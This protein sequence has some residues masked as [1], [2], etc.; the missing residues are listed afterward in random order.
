LISFKERE[1]IFQ[2]KGTVKGQ[3]FGFALAFVGDWNHDHR[4]D[5]A[6][7]GGADQRVTI[8]SGM[9]HSTIRTL[10]AADRITES[11]F[12]IALARLG[13]LDGD[14]VSELAVGA[15]RTRAA[16]VAP[17]ADVPTR[18]A[19]GPGEPCGSVYIF[20]SR[21][22]GLIRELTEPVARSD[23]Y[24]GRS[25]S[26]A[27]D[28]DGDGL[29][30]LIVGAP[31]APLETPE[32]ARPVSSSEGKWSTGRAFLFSGKS[33]RLLRELNLDLPRRRVRVF[34]F[35]RRRHRS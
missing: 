19:L 30:D 28:V 14:G 4:D 12:G 10:E 24:F 33:G 8:V 23:A 21:S 5:L 29:D 1:Q 20:S 17:A 25:I 27:G 7:S 18:T 26:S 6:I 16:P 32:D 11:W 22:G 13:D 2:S 3:G 35:G 15:P 31:G 34:R 9:D